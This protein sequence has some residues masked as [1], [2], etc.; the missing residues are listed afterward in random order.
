MTTI[1]NGSSP[2][3]T[4][5]D[6]TTQTTAGLTG[7]TQQL[8]QAWGLFS[9]NGSGITINASYNVSSITLSAT[10][11]YR[12]TMTNAMTD[13][14][15]AVVLGGDSGATYSQG[16]ILLRQSATNATTSSAFTIGSYN[17]SSTAS[18]SQNASFAVYR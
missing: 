10:G 11:V 1:I 9:Y 14:N 16:Y 17:L 18:N 7:S 2:S 4:F 13:T 15:Y 6:N 12:I 8:C 3:I 5:S